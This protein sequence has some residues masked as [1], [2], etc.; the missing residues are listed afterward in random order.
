MSWRPC[1]RSCPRSLPVH[2][3]GSSLL[4]LIAW[5]FPC[6]ITEK[7]KGVPEKIM[8]KVL[9]IVIFKASDYAMGK[10][11]PLVEQHLFKQE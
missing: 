3:I 8:Q 11:I 4:V 9:E 1:S 2:G 5:L 10:L 6:Y 7:L